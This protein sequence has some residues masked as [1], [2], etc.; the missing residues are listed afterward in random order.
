MAGL[1]NPLDPGAGKSPN[2]AGKAADI[3]VD[4]VARRFPGPWSKDYKEPKK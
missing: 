4:I 3:A 1:D 2:L